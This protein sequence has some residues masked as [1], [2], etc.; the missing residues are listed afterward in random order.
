MHPILWAISW[1]GEA[2]PKE[3]KQIDTELYEEFRLSTCSII[4]KEMLLA[5]YFQ[6]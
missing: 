2:K 6:T 3:V 1:N 5:L 4:F